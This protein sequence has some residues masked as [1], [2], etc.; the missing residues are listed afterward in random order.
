[1]ALTHPLVLAL[2]HAAFLAAGTLLLYRA[3]RGS[4]PGAA[5]AAAAGFPL[6]AES[7]RT[8]IGWPTQFVDVGLFCFSAAAI[9]EA[10]RRRLPTAMGALLA[11]LLCK[12]LAL[13]TALLLPLLPGP[14]L[15][16]RRRTWAV[17][18]AGVVAVWA[19]AYLAVRH[20]AHL[21]L[22]HGIESDPSVAAVGLPARLAWALGG[23]LESLASLPIAVSRHDLPAAAFG[24]ALV[25]GI[26]IAAARSD[27]VRRRLAARRAWLAWGAAWFALCTAAL[28]SIYPLWQP[29]RAHV[30]SVGAGVALA[31]AAEAAHP[32][33]L[34]G[35]VGGRAVLLALAPH[36]A[37]T[38]TRS[39]P[40]TGAFID[41]AKLTRL[42]HTLRATR[43]ALAGVPRPAPGSVIVFANAPRST[44]YALGGDRAVQVWWRDSTLRAIA[45]TEF[46]AHRDRPVAAFLQFQADAAR[47]VVVVPVGAA[48]EQ[49]RAFAALQVA[50]LAGGL[51]AEDRADS[52]APDPG[53]TVFHAGTA[54][55]RA[56]TLYGLGRF[57]PAVGEARRALALDPSQSNARITLAAFAYDLGEYDDAD[58][59]LD[60]LQR[61]D[62]ANDKA[63]VLRERVAVA[64][65][66]HLPGTLHL[67]AP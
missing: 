15:R 34:A 62:P 37:R 25:L 11:A 29:N 27:A 39:A 53:L 41:F 32:A 24:L 50:D 63:V 16:G 13:V 57:E 44:L 67:R 51:V 33:L 55:Y 12:E 46:R 45:V 36:A 18:V 47:E 21:V 59:Q 38:T 31:A 35:L 54:G 49:E 20:A 40:E 3:F 1:M 23:T 64:R 9:H 14:A 17:T 58:R 8:L 43:L 19:A 28:S 7:T 4:L 60:T 52:L 22:P 30:G 2:V 6:F 42:Q 61:W 26:A 5:A 48:R 65:S 56:L 10:S 66:R